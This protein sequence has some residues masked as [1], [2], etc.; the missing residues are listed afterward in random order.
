MYLPSLTNEELLRYAEAMMVP[1][2]TSD[3]ER[4]LIK[5]LSEREDKLADEI[6]ALNSKIAELE[7]ELL[8]VQERME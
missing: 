3:L 1:L 8:E 2:A 4:E 7:G 5:R 6:R